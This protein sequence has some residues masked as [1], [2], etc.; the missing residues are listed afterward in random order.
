M[1]NSRNLTYVLI[2][3]L[4]GGCSDDKTGTPKKDSSVVVDTGTKSDS[5]ATADST[6][7][8]PDTSVTPDGAVT[9]GTFGKPCSVGGC[10][11]DSCI[12]G[13]NWPGEGICT[14]PCTTPGG[15]E[16]CPGAPAG[17]NA[18][19]IFSSQGGNCPCYCAFFCEDNRTGTKQ[20]WTCPTGT[21]CVVPIADTN[22]KE[23]GKICAPLAK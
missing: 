13:T 5:G 12:R 17:T 18:R 4:V 7:I 23:V 20:T 11:G 10:T 8:L 2:L 6:I 9:N 3:A 22:G 14:K 16:I 21:E 15:A 1:K 19:C